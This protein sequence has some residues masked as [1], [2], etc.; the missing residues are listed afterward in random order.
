MS[1]EESSCIRGGGVEAP[2]DPRYTCTLASLRVNSATIKHGRW[3]FGEAP[4]EHMRHFIGRSGPRQSRLRVQS[5]DAR[6]CRRCASVLCMAGMWRH[7]HG[8]ELER[9]DP[10]RAHL[11]N[12]TATNCSSLPFFFLSSSLRDF[13][14]AKQV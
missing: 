11:H 13:V 6:S 8:Q 14:T 1:V 3:R 9:D 10:G 5:V 12:N 7:G 2:H 4:A